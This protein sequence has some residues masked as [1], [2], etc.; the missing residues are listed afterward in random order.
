VS[1][2]GLPLVATTVLTLLSCS[3]PPPG[4]PPERTLTF[5][6]RADVRGIYPDIGNES[7]SFGVNSNLFEGLTR[8]DRSLKPQPALAES[9]E[10]PDEVTWLFH[11]RKGVRF[12]DGRAVLA[13]DVVASIL[14]A[15]RR[16]PQPD[17]F[18]NHESVEA[19][20]D[21]VVRIRTRRPDPL[22]LTSLAPLFVLPARVLEER[23]F[24]AVGTGPYIFERWTPGHELVFVR[25]P[26]YL[27]TPASFA[28]LRFVV[29]PDEKD[30][31]GALLRGEAQVAEQ[32]SSLG[33]GMIGPEAP[34]RVISRPGLHVLFLALRMKEKPLSDP[35]VREAFNLA[36]D[37]D[38]LVRGP[39]Q[40]RAQ[41]A[42]QIVTPAVM[43]YNPAV[44]RP[45]PDPDRARALLSAAGYPHGFPIR[46]D[47]TSDHYRSDVQILENVAQQL[48]RIGVRV[49]VNALPKAQFFALQEALATRFYLLGW[50][51]ESLQAGEALGSL[52][53]T[54]T[55]S[56][57]GSENS[58][59]LSD[60]RLDALIEQA[61]GA[62]DLLAKADLLQRA[63]ARL[64]ELHA[65]LPLVI[66]QET[67]GVARG[68]LWEPPL[69]GG[70]R[71]IDVLPG[72]PRDPS[73]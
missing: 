29:L 45:H 73:S 3:A 62:D 63:I 58:Q 30:R 17:Y 70:L 21:D 46:L 54:P 35:R 57:L 5:A 2:R 69:D 48:G 14:F 39:L 66:P 18:L 37:R 16:Q 38:E 65:I 52:A 8:L 22:L 31:V 20:S 59:F 64:D 25:N 4:P 68:L 51:C 71:A 55:S 10:N 72:G 15:G 49:E 42:D 36:L 67:Y 50:S 60:P 28:H 6:V 61:A 19:V 27:G 11:L 56:G 1:P 53:H 12:S 33:E 13:R 23:P 40:G 41:P 24:R 9:W 44:K 47:G 34:A 7:F 32:I 26:Y 43:G